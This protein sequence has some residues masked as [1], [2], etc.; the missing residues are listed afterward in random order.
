MKTAKTYEGQI[1]LGYS[2]DTYDSDGN[3]RSKKSDVYPDENTLLENMKGFTGEIDQIPPPYS[4]K[5]YKGEALYKRVRMEKDY[6]LKPARVFIHFFNLKKYSPPLLDFEVK[7]SSGTYIR[8]LAHDLG[9]N[10]G[11]GAHLSRLVRMQIGKFNIRESHSVEEIEE[12]HATG[13][14]HKFLQPIESLLSDF[15]SIIAKN[16]DVPHI[17][18]GREFYADSI[19]ES[20]NPEDEADGEESEKRPIFRVFDANGRLL[21]FATKNKET[22]SLHPFMVFKTEK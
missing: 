12:L 7:C 14:V 3:P 9:Q 11:C 18:N 13:Q 4:A 15:P 22:D 17:K 21:A 16:E 2:T 6:E 8:S 5:K 20:L 19:P 1:R 10:L